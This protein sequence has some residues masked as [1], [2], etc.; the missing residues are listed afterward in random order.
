MEFTF[1]SFDKVRK[2]DKIDLEYETLGQFD[3][4]QILEA[5]LKIE[6]KF[7]DKKCTFCF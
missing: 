2:R 4:K 3:N 5:T 1:K 7:G 6:I